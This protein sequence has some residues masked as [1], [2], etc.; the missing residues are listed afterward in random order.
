MKS[1]KFGESAYAKANVGQVAP[2]FAKGYGRAGSPVSVSRLMSGG[3][4]DLGKFK[5]YRAFSN[6]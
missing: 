4:Q 3:S 6:S 5:Y 2:A 1:L